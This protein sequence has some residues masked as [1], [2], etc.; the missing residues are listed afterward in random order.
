M[1]RASKITLASVIAATG[2]IVTGVHYIQ[3]QEHRTM[4]EGVL[5]DQE[6]VRIK[7]ERMLELEQQ[8]AM[9]REYEAAQPLKRADGGGGA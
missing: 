6:R 3:E 2:L 1:S 4:Y 8:Q 5:K 9:Q 7:K